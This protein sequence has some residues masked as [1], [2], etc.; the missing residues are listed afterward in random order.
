[1]A[2]FFK[3]IKS[4]IVTVIIGSALLIFMSIGAVGFMVYVFFMLGTFIYKFSQ[5]MQRKRC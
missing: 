3:I 2:A 4:L 1:M 5:M